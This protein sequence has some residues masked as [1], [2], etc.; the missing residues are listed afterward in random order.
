MGYSILT[1]GAV[2]VRVLPQCPMNSGNVHSGSVLFGGH[3]LPFDDFWQAFFWRFLTVSCWSNFSMVYLI[4]PPLIFGRNTCLLKFQG[5]SPLDF[6]V[7][8]GLPINLRNKLNKWTLLDRKVRSHFIRA[9]H[10]QHHINL[11]QHVKWQTS[12]HSTNI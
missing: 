9:K 1:T 5:K 6:H 7:T 2:S 12:C 8:V 11:S 10:Y 4:L 3:K